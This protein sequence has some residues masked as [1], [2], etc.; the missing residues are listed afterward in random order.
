[1]PRVRTLD[2]KKILF[3]TLMSIM[4]I[5]AN[6]QA[7]QQP[8]KGYFANEEYHVYMRIDLYGDGFD[9]PDHE[10]YGPLPGFLAKERNGFYWVI[11]SAEVLSETKAEIELINDFGSED[12][13]ATLTLE[14]DGATLV[15][16]Q[17]KGSTI[18]VPKDGKWMKL[19]GKLEFKRK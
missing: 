11:T 2:M 15:L 16:K 14:D 7:A 9:I 4:A 3:I 1:M 13:K 6:A 18:K 5:A 19:P 17:G 8:F 12:L 10:L